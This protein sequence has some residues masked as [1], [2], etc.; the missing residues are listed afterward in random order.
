MKKIELAKEV[1]AKVKDECYNCMV[2][3]TSGG[4]HPDGFTDYDQSISLSREQILFL[5]KNNSSYDNLFEDIETQ[6]VNL[7][8]IFAKMGYES[9]WPEGG[10]VTRVKGVVPQECVDL[11]QALCNVDENDD[12]EVAKLR[13]ALL[14]LKDGEYTFHIDVSDRDG[15]NYF[16]EDEPY[17]FY[18]S[19]DEI[20]Q[21]LHSEFKG[22]KAFNGVCDK[23]LNKDF[24]N[25]KAEAMNIADEFDYYFYVGQS[26]PLENYISSWVELIDRIMEGSVT[27]ANVDQ[28]LKYFEDSENW[29]SDIDGLISSVDFS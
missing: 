23:S 17:K 29:E 25:E 10:P 18:L 26:E 9:S 22:N 16:A 1:L 21:L 13:D 15:W 14:S 2:G 6:E 28:M 8:E 3:C 27:E 24:L 19:G 12:Y 11:A 7:D 4:K 20:R 5:I